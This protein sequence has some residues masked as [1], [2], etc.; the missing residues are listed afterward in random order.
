MRNG[1]QALNPEGTNP[2]A[3]GQP[4]ENPRKHFEDL[5]AEGTGGVR[6]RAADAEARLIAHHLNAAS[7]AVTHADSLENPA[8][9]FDLLAL[10]ND[11]PHAANA[12]D[13][14]GT[15]S[16]FPQSSTVNSGILCYLF[17]P[18]I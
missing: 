7:L 3:E 2:H 6:Q 4:L 17:L 10:T 16:I 11:K 12:G 8:I 14:K 18:Q 15:A 1:G 13:P 9:L 5:V